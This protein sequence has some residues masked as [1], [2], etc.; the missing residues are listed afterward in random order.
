LNGLKQILKKEV[1]EFQ[2][3]TKETDENI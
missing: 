1:A 3:D 2:N